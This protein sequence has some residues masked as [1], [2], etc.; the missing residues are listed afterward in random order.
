MFRKLIFLMA[1]LTS[2]SALAGSNKPIIAKQ[3]MAVSAHYLATRVGY[4]V[5]RQGGNAVDAAIAMGYALAVVY[6]CCGNLGGGGFMLIRFAD[7]KTTFINFREKAPLKL[8]PGYFINSKGKVIYKN[9]STHYLHGAL[10]KPYLAVGVPGTV[11][12]LNT[13]LSKYGTLSLSKVVAPAIQLAERGFILNQ[14]DI[15]IFKQNESSFKNQPNVAKIFLKN[16]QSF[17]AGDRLIQ[18]EL[19]ATLKEIAVKGEEAFYNGKIAKTIIKASQQQGGVL[20]RKDLSAYQVDEQRPVVCTY[21]KF[22]V[23]TTPPPG[24]GATICEALKILE[25]FPLAKYGFH[26]VQGTHEIA[27]ALRFA[28]ADR[29]TTLG[30]PL[31]INNPV[32]QLLSPRHIRDIQHRIKFNQ[33]TP[34]TSIKLIH[35][36]GNNTTSYVVLDRQGN[37]VSVT[38][39][40]NDFFGAK[41]IPGNTGFFLNNEMADFTI[42]PT[43]ANNYGLYQGK[44]NLLAP[45]KRPLSSMAPTI[46][47]RDNQLFMII[48]TPGGSTIPSQLINVIVNVIDYDMNLQAAENAPRFH[49]QWLPD[50]IF[51]EPNAFSQT[52]IRLLKKMGYHFRRGSPYDTERWGAV[53]GILYDSSLKRI[54]GAMDQ[55]AKNGA[56]MGK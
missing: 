45:G 17:Q 3:F 25:K 27:E 46:L 1:L 49:M 51:M 26:S 39:T 42:K 54:E 9:L 43:V 41:V 34:S 52:T 12:G 10:T 55:R 28:Y 18:P 16:G 40:L 38:Y 36:E 21:K 2:I 22:Q 20:T 7:G 30:D 19:A 47:T 5:L 24:S 15:D 29:N 50:V 11:L 31:Y 8:T 48:G 35:Q 4:E 33:A 32:K 23:I 14:A 37:A 53:S 13:A 6:P 56:A 44:Q